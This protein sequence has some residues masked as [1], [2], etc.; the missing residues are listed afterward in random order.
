MVAMLDFAAAHGVA[1]DDVTVMPFSSLNG[2]IER[3]RSREA[4]TAIVLESVD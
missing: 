4:V 1:V 2:A 3:V